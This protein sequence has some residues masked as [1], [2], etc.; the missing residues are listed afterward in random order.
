M[1]M[2]SMIGRSP[3]MEAPTPIP[4]KEFSE[5]GVS[6][7]RDSPYFWNSPEVAL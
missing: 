6:M 3:A 5:I 1:D 4:V 2:I 7:T